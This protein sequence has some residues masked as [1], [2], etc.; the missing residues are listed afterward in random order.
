M[1]LKLR[2]FP[3]TDPAV[4]FSGDPPLSSPETAVP[5]SWILNCR[6]V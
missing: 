3:I 6:G 1:T 2:S 5:S 4:T